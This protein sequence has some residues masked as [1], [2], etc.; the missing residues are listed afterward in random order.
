MFFGIQRHFNYENQTPI[1]YYGRRNTQGVFGQVDLDYN[2]YLYLSLS[3]RN[4]WVSNLPTENNSMFYPSASVSFIP[5]AAFD[6]LKSETLS[7]LKVRA[8]Y[9]SSASFPTGYPT[10]N[11]V[12]QST[13]QNGGA[14]GELLLTQLV[15]SKLTLN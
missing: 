13:N 7:Y 6:D 12:S 1:A 2:D 15:T 14:L 3:A 8:G 9:G 10:V 4:D 11:T 5:T